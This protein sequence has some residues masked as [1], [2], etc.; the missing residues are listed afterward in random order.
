MRKS[1]RCFNTRNTFLILDE[2]VSKG[3]KDEKYIPPNWV[4]IEE[5][6]VILIYIGERPAQ[7]RKRQK[8]S[9]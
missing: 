1:E 6:C 5:K 9:R 4:I 7:R 8:L 2:K 3:V